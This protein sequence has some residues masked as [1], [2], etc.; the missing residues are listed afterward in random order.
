[1]PHTRSNDCDSPLKII[2]Y[3]TQQQ[4]YELEIA[5]RRFLTM[6]NAKITIA[7][8]KLRADN[9]IILV[10]TDLCSVFLQNYLKKAKNK[11]RFLRKTWPCRVTHSY[12]ISI[13]KQI[14]SIAQPI[15]LASFANIYEQVFTKSRQWTRRSTVHDRSQ[16]TS[17]HVSNKKMYF[18][19][20]AKYFLKTVIRFLSDS[21]RQMYV[22]FLST[23]IVTLYRNIS[24]LEVFSLDVKTS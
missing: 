24:Y 15:R 18:K 16:K 23:G 13:E 20:K 7:S 12:S 2:Y 21:C 22:R 5:I 17:S 9:L 8:Q 19:K 6:T 10:K 4:G 1:M 3:S 14:A 11:C